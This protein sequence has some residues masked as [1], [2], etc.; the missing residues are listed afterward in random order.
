M[1]MKSY[2]AL[3]KLLE[4]NQN[5]FDF[6]F[7]DGFH[8]FDYTLLDFFYSNLLLKINGY[9]LID[10]ALHHGVNKCIEYI[11]NNY[12]DSYKKIDS[13]VTFALF[14]KI[15]EDKREWNFHKNF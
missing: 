12:L 2:I 4:K 6:I 8:T 7:I 5:K 1:E 9:I 15:N 11:K 10:D 14:K 13:P 3:P